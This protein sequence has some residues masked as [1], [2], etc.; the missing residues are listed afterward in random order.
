MKKRII[1]LSIL[2]S[3]NNALI[4]QVFTE[5]C[6]DLITIDGIT[7]RDSVKTEEEVK[8]NLL[9]LK[10]K[11]QDLYTKANQDCFRNGQNICNSNNPSR[12]EA[13]FLQLKRDAAQRMQYYTKLVYSVLG[14]SSKSDFTQKLENIKN[15]NVVSFDDICQ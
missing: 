8:N 6:G 14:N 10:N 12:E 13:E 4:A 7:S 5:L 2:F 11:W 9:D 15:Q 1:C 3:I